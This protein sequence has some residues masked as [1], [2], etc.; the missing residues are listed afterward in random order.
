MRSA[1]PISPPG[2]TISTSAPVQE[3]NGGLD[4]AEADARR[5][6]FDA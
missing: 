4:F 3:D 1:K 6:S 5:E 2:Q